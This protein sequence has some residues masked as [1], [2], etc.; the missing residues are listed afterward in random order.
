MACDVMGYTQLWTSESMKWKSRNLG[1]FIPDYTKSHPRIQYFLMLHVRYSQTPIKGHPHLGRMKVCQHKFT[2]MRTVC[3][4]HRH[5]RHTTWN[6]GRQWR[7]VGSWLYFLPSR[8]RTWK[9][10]KRDP[11]ITEL[12]DQPNGVVLWNF[13]FL[14]TLIYYP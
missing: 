10:R 8:S 14:H 1:K 5:R 13:P 2:V 12:L 11:K 3:H 6:C 9:N 4:I 7:Y